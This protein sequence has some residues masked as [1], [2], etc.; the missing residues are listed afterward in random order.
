MKKKLLVISGSSG[1][2]KGTVINKLLKNRNDIKL[3][4]SCTTRKPREGEEHGKQYFFLSTDEF[5][6]G[7]EE[8]KF[9]EW[10]EF[11]GNYYGTSREFIEKNLS[12]GY[13]VLLEIETDGALQIKNKIPDCV[14]IFIAPPSIEELERRLRGRN[15]ETEDAIQKRLSMVKTELERSKNYDYTVVNDEVEKAANR[16][17]EIIDA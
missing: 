7:L 8:D 5:K 9:I 13:H 16:I 10:T 3:S 1:V 2:G 6:K 12:N 4:I 11:S 17:S 14:M 15:T